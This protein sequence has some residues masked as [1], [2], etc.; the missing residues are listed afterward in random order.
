[1][2]TLVLLA[3]T[4]ITV[5]STSAQS[6]DTPTCSSG[7]AVHDPDNNP[8]LVSDC[9]TLLAARDALGGNPTLYWATDTPIARWEG[10]TVGGTPER[11]TELILQNR[12]LNGE[13]PSELGDLANLVKLDLKG[14]QLTGS[15][16]AELGKAL[17]PR[18]PRL[19]L[20]SIDRT[21]TDGTGRPHKPREAV[22][23]P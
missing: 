18:T 9:E 6:N 14:N 10:V 3:S 15:I 19:E 23:G 8:G 7:T 20:E 5:P 17:Q 22:V 11:V 13:I 2:A 16:P 21:D 12:G 4:L 1:M